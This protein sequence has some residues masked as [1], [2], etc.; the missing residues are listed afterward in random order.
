MIIQTLELTNFRNYANASITLTNGVTAIVGNNGQGKTNLT[1]ALSFLATLKSFRGVPNEAMIRIGANSAVIRAVVV[2]DDGREVLIEAELVRVGRNKVQVNRQKLAKTRDLLG[3]MRTTV[4]SPEDLELVK[5]SP[6]VR[7]DFLDDAL[8][9]I[10]P[11]VDAVRSAFERVLKQRNALLKQ[12]NGR[13]TP[14]IASTLDVW[15]EKF[16]LLGTELGELRSRLIAQ[17]EPEVLRAYEELAEQETPISM[18]YEPLWRR[19][20]LPTELATHRNDDVRRGSSTVGPHRDDIELLINGLAARSHASQGEQRTL[21]LAM[22]LAVHRLVTQSAGSSPVLILDDV[23]SE[24]DPHRSAALLRH[25]PVGQVLITT[26][27]LLPEAAHPDRIVRISAGAIV[28]DDQ[29]EHTSS[30]P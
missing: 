19:T 20:G 28:P 21:A 10:T 23:L 25:F 24:L 9:A 27:D 8:V 3:V 15:D 12:A 26:A 14:D 16:V 1:E 17:I 18:I 13:L 2:H 30:Q 11:H 29:T 6:G 7:R 22:R 4:F 5:D